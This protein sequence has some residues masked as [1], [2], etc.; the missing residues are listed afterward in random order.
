MDYPEDEPSKEERRRLNKLEHKRHPTCR[1]PISTPLGV[2]QRMQEFKEMLCKNENGTACISK[3]LQIAMD[4]EHPG[5]MGALKMCMDRLLPTS[6]FEEKKEDG[7]RS[8]ININI[9][10][11]S[12]EINGETIDG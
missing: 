12:A 3:V 7:A 4:D 2:K 1:A 11:L 8:M 6:M 5:Q 9:T 10:G